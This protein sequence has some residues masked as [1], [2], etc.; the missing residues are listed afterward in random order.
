MCRGPRFD[1]A[2][3]Q[4]LKRGAVHVADL[5]QEVAQPG[6]RIDAFVG[7]TALE[8][9]SAVIATGDAQDIKRLAAPYGRISLMQL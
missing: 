7:A 6:K 5:T 9:E 1:A 3:N 4:P 8:F 2:V